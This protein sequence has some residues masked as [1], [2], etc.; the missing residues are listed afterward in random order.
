MLLNVAFT[1]HAHSSSKA[2]SKIAIISLYNEGYRKVGQYSDWNKKAY[3]KKHG[4]DLFLYHKLLDTTR[5]PAW[6][7][8]LAIQEHLHE[9]EWIFWSDADSLVMNNETRLESIIDNNYDMI[10]T[11]EETG[12]GN[13]NTG[14]FL[15]KNSQWSQQL[16]A[17]IY[18]KVDFIN[19][20]AWEQAAF[21]HLFATNPSYKDHI[22]I[23][24][25]RVMNSHLFSGG[26]EYHSGDFVLHFYGSDQLLISIYGK[27]KAELMKQYYDVAL[28]NQLQK[29]FGSSRGSLEHTLHKIA[30]R[31]RKF[32]EKRQLYTNVLVSLI[33][34][35]DLKIG[36]E[37]GVGFGTHSQ[38]VLL[39]TKVTK[40][41]CIDPYKYF[42]KEYQDNM[43]LDQEEFDVL[44]FKI[45]RMFDV[46]DQRVELIRNTSNK[47]APEFEQNELDFVFLDANQTVQSTIENIDIWFK[48]VRSGGIIAGYSYHKKTPNMLQDVRKFFTS[49]KIMFNHDSEYPVWWIIKP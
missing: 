28:N 18:K 3:A 40:L 14:S 8:I 49:K 43:R 35:Y 16:L 26:G 34:K 29:I 23:L 39:K 22:K 42:N 41:Y 31:E 25:Q 13:L 38:A 47:V 1:S 46:F 15:L 24:R 19:A 9:Y 4:Y 2:R 37:I 27:P 30:K 11:K 17:D 45:N 21:M 6:S 48:K 10:V 32:V 33:N 7:K 12:P 5:P 36:A 44:Y 20:S